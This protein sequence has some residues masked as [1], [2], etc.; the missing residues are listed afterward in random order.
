MGSLGVIWVQSAKDFLGIAS[1]FELVAGGHLVEVEVERSEDNLTV[2]SRHLSTR[3]GRNLFLD[4]LGLRCPLVEELVDGLDLF[5]ADA[6]IAH[7]GA[8][9]EVEL[10]DAA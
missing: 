10:A 6:A 9:V 2:L 3:L 1:R 5:G 4:L 7:L 8:A